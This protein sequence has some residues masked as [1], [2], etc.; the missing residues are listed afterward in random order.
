MSIEE[1]CHRRAAI[2]GAPWKYE[3]TGQTVFGFSPGGCN[4]TPSDYMV[5]DIRGWGHLQYMGIERGDK[6]ARD[7]QDANGEFIAHAPEDVSFLLDEI[8]RL[9]NALV[10]VAVCNRYKPAH[11]GG[12]EY[13]GQCCEVCD[14]D[15]GAGDALTHTAD[16][17]LSVLNPQT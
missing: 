3:S 6:V 16:C 1:I 2:D 14:A 10:K 13:I 11:D 17:P 7:M 12:S 5:A 15:C 9:R 4:K 8:G